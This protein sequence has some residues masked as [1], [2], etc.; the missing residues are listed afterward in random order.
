MFIK[1]GAYCTEPGKGDCLVSHQ[2]SLLRKDDILFGF[3]NHLHQGLTIF[4][5]TE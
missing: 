3:G 5:I 1:V 2:L 4:F